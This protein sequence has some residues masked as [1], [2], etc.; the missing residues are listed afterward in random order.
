MRSSHIAILLTTTFA[1]ACGG[2]EA[3]EPGGQACPF[4]FPSP[5]ETFTPAASPALLTF[6]IFPD[7]GVTE[8]GADGAAAQYIVE[9]PH[10][11]VASDGSTDTS[12][13]ISYIQNLQGAAVLFTPDEVAAEYDRLANNAAQIFGATTSPSTITL[14]GEEVNVL[15]AR[16][17]AQISM[18]VFVPIDDGAFFA[19]TTITVNAARSGCGDT[20]EETYADLEASVALNAT[21]TFNEI[22]TVAEAK[23]DK[24]E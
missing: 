22:E 9:V 4:T 14:G 13:T 12:A 3:N 15:V 11:F 20:L 21:T 16:S 8:I 10:A 5:T 23:A 19:P 1:F 7:A 17:D 18:T 6:G 24:S 2:G